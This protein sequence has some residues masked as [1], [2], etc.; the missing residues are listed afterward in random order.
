VAGERRRQ[1]RFDID[2]PVR[3][4]LP[5]E[6]DRLSAVIV[7]VS[8]GG[9]FVNTGRHAAVGRPAAVTFRCRSR[10]CEATGNV[11]RYAAG[12]GFAVQCHEANQAFLDFLVELGEAAPEER[13]ALVAQVQDPQ[14]Q[15]W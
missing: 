4:V 7:D 12:D 5:P 1:P 6:M 13:A 10:I 11:V 15:V 9:V 3:L 8:R 2:L 14:I